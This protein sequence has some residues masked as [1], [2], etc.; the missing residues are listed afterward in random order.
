MTFQAP[1]QP[2]LLLPYALLWLLLIFYGV[3]L[4]IRLGYSVFRLLVALVFG[5]VALILW[6]IPQTEWV[7]WLWLRELLAWATT[8]LLVTACLALASV[9]RQRRS[10]VA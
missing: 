5:P 10:C 3:R 9:R 4:V 8:P 1:P 2:S 6:A 7:T